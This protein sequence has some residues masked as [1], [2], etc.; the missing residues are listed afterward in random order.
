MFFE[1]KWFEFRLPHLRPWRVRLQAQGTARA[2]R[3]PPRRAPELHTL[4][5]S[6]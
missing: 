1:E 2:R 4:S 5:V 3:L 6:T